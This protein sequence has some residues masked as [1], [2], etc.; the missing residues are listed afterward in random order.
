M[1]FLSVIV[2]SLLSVAAANVDEAASSDGLAKRDSGSISCSNTSVGSGCGRSSCSQAAHRWFA[3]INGQGY[4]AGIFSGL[5]TTT[6]SRFPE[7]RNVNGK[8]LTFWQ[9]ADG[10][11]NVQYDGK[12]GWCCGASAGGS[13]RFSN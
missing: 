11:W 3:N 10:C 4:D 1:K 8:D 12:H 9:T 2:A 13:C 5:C 6:P 7:R